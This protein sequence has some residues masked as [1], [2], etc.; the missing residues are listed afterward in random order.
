MAITLNGPLVLAGAGK[1]G[2]ALLEG[3]LAS[4]L[5]PGQVI[6]QDPNLES[7][8]RDQLRQRGIRVETS[9]EAIQQPPAVLLVAVK[10]QVMDAVFPA[11]A[12]LAGPETITLSVA[13]GKD[14]ESFAQ[15]LQPNAPIVRAMPNTPASIGYGMTVCVAN[16][17]V[18]AEQRALCDTLLNTVGQ[19]AWVE[20]EAQMDAVTAISGSGPAYIFYMAECMTRAGVALG[21]DE[22]TASKLANATVIGAGAL[23]GES[24]APPST[25]RE[26]VTSPAGTTA[27]ALSVLMDPEKGLEALMKATTAAAAE[28]SRHLSK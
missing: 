6:V 3:M 20:N 14:M 24:N 27:A 8:T 11:L 7:S 5:D 18:T 1:M 26:N 2:G 9:L 19:V 22:A 23:I 13:A 10:P 15:F 21:L 25:L 16:N 28:R 12:K 17:A 4:G